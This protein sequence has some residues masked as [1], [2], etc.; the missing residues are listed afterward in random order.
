MYSVPSDSVCISQS[1]ERAK[2]DGIFE[3]LG[4]V[5]GLLSGD[6]VKPVLMNSKLPLD[7]LGRVSTSFTP[8]RAV[9][10]TIIAVV[11]LARIY[12]TNIEINQRKFERRNPLM[13][14]MKLELT[15]DL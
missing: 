15:C 4:P 2:F 6:K 11:I 9:M 1:D 5:K 13:R 12:E 10:I 14:F 3:S 8:L 7:A